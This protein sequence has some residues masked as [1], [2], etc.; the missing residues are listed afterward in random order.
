MHDHVF[1]AT[2]VSV[3]FVCMG[4]ICRSPTAEGV[5]RRKVR[6]AG[7]ED[8]VIVDSAGTH[9]YHVGS[10][11]D[12]RSQETAARRGYDL[13]RLRARKFEADDCQRF[14]Y[15]LAMDRGNYNRIVQ[16]CRAGGAHRAGV[17][18]GHGEHEAGLH[19]GHG[20]GDHGAGLGAPA[21]DGYA[22]V[23][24]FLEFAPYLRER[25]VPDPYA[26][27]DEGFEYVLD[28]IE[29]AADGLLEDVRQRLAGE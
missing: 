27:S 18:H 29:A 25:E 14:D 13:S 15:V 17:R 12:A 3:L 5:F 23:R 1:A 9:G 20:Q 4:N 21:R 22:N 7:L 10:P 26:G 24:M 19:A 28:L 8:R 6:E 2:T 16:T 11:P